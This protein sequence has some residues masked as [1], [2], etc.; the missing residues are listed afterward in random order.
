[1]GPLRITL[2]I[3]LLSLASLTAAGCGSDSPSSPSSGGS[4]G[5]S[6]GPIAA[7]LTITASGIA[8]KTVNVPVGSRVTIVNN[9]S[10]SH[11]MN[12]DPHPAHT[13]CPAL[14][15]GLL[16]AGQSRTSQNLTTARNCG[17]HD[18]NDPDNSV[19][20]TTITVQ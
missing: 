10:R 18:H 5:G 13:N 12:S 20:W 19:W 14:N 16:S 2:V 8:P 3:G 11:D 15:V 7:T 6:D 9:D 1:M 4:G 17:M